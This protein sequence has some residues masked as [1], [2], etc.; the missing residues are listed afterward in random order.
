MVKVIKRAGWAV[1]GFGLAAAA[2]F[3][4]GYTYAAHYLKPSETYD[5]NWTGHFLFMGFCFLTGVLSMFYSAK[6]SD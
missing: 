6:Y 3:G 1:F 4:E 2:I 5:I